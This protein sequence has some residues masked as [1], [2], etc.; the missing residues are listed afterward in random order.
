MRMGRDKA[1]LPFG[2][3]MML[4]RVV[5]QVGEVVADERIVVVAAPQQILPGLPKDV[6]VARDTEE[7][8][9]PLAG[10]AV[11]LPALLDKAD[12][13]DTVYATGCDFPLLVPA[14]IERMFSLLAEF[15][16]AVPVE[17]GQ[18]HMLASVHRPR[19]LRNIK[20][21]LATGQLRLQS[22]LEEIN[23]REVCADE[24]RA[25]DPSLNSLRNVNSEEE[26]KA[27]LAAAGICNE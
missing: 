11:G 25:V 17:G 20:T 2:P 5:R 14:F 24:L 4:Q 23:V 6:I 7:H 1:S 12:I 18:H 26:Y 27:A 10:L 9:G 19:V 15:D 3:E 22:L 13:V 21:L 8:L 16:A